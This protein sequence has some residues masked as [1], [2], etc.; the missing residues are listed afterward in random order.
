LQSERGPLFASA[1]DFDQHDSTW[2]KMDRNYFPG[3]PEIRWPGRPGWI[4]QR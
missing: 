4:E 2:R 1:E 3:N